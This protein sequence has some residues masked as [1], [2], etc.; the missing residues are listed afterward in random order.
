MCDTDT[1][2]ALIQMTRQTSRGG[3]VLLVKT[4]SIPGS[5]C[6]KGD[7]TLHSDLRVVSLGSKWTVRH[8]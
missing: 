8:I 6:Q 5:R 1:H 2:D 3:M 7:C 4:C